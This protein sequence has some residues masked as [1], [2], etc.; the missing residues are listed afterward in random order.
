MKVQS[1]TKSTFFEAHCVA[2]LRISMGVIFCWFGV[3]KFVPGLSPAE[4]LAGRT[5]EALSVGLVHP[6]LSLPALALFEC[7]LGALLISGRYPKMAILFLLAHMIGTFSPALFFPREV[8]R[9][10][11]LPT[12][13]GQYIL[14]NI[15]LIAAGIVV[16]AGAPTK[17]DTRV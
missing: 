11:M 3:L 8:F 2:I 17:S 7:A 14:K 4:A 6:W 10:F 16:S 9:G 1:L 12:L 5:I 13:V 15:I